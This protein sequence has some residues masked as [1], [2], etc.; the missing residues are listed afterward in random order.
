MT[1]TQIKSELKRIHTAR[2]TLN[3]YIRSSRVGLTFKM[4]RTDK[5]AVYSRYVTEVN[6][7]SCITM[8]DISRKGMIAYNAITKHRD[9]VMYE[10]A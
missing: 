4:S 2:M 8:G 6:N 1:E 10:G 5:R 3:E 7:A 9:E